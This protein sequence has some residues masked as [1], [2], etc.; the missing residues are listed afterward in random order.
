MN[1]DHSPVDT[2]NMIPINEI[3][4]SVVDYRDEVALLSANA[5][6]YLGSMSWCKR[7]INGWVAYANGYIIGVFYFHIEPSNKQ[8]P[9]YIWVINGDIPPAYIDVGYC[10]TWE[11][12]LDGYIAEMQEWVDRVIQG[13]PIDDSVIPVN[14]PPEKIW[15]ERLQSRLDLLRPIVTDDA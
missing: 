4:A 14:V 10:N 11:L 1:M 8:V 13:R 9:D 2:N 3:A 7:I 6:N 12:A 15:A 5:A